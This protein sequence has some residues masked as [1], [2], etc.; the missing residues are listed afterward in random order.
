MSYTRKVTYNTL[1]QIIGRVLTTVSSLATVALLNEGLQAEGWGIYAAVTTYI[2]LFAVFADMGINSLYLRE[3]SRYPDQEQELTAKYLGFRLSTALFLMLLAP[4]VARVVPAYANYQS[5][6]WIV[7]LGQFF[8]L[9]NQIF[10]NLFQ[11]RLVMGRAVVTDLLGRLLILIGTIFVVRMYHESGLS[12]IFWVVV[13]GNALNMVLSYLLAASLLPI[14]ISLR[15]SEW[16]A[17]LLKALPMGALTVLG[18]IHFKADS[19]ILAMTRPIEEVGIYG[20]SYKVIEILLTFP[21]MFVGS[22]FPAIAKAVIDKD[23]ALPGF[24]QK[25]FDLLAFICLPMIVTLFVL[26]P[27]IITVLTRNNIYPSTISLQIL[28]LAMIPWFLGSLAGN[29][30]LAYDRQKELS[31]VTLLA[32]TVNIVLNVLIIP[33][34]SYYGAAVVTV[35]T[36]ALTALLAY[37]LLRR[38]V[39]FSPSWRSLTRSLPVMAVV[40]AICLS[41]DWIWG[42]SFFAVYSG[43]PRSLEAAVLCLLGL[44]CML[45]YLVPLILFKSFP[46]VLQERVGRLLARR[47][48]AS[49]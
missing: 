21:G 27:Y 31:L 39:S 46:D 20:N 24:I 43:W 1:V 16:K 34:Y 32:V 41:V 15:T 5:F 17:L 13:A 7:S 3:V 49:A 4:T 10:V 25:A 23:A 26:A 47:K 40:T 30:L 48:G 33:R 22:L 14:R 8:L 11:A 36:E 19:F 2:G 9:V 12:Y 35:T 38:H 42:K 37:G 18:L 28:V 45:M 29:V 6:I 44:A